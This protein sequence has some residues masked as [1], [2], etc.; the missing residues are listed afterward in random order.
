[1]CV[2]NVCVLSVCACR[3]CV[4]VCACVKVC[5][6]GVCK[7]VQKVICQSVTPE[8]DD[9]EMKRVG[10]L[11]FNLMFPTHTHHLTTTQN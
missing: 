9:V 10:L 2:L 3:A 6:I 5:R 7:V 8:T 4:F 1:V 11:L